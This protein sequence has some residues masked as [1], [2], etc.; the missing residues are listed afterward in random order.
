M[1]RYIRILRLPFI[2]SKGVGSTRHVK[3]NNRENLSYTLSKRSATYMLPTLV[4]V[5]WRC[6]SFSVRCSHYLLPL[7][8]T[9]MRTGAKLASLEDQD[10]F[11]L[12]IIMTIGGQRYTYIKREL[13]SQVI[14]QKASAATVTSYC[15]KIFDR[16]SYKLLCFLLK[17]IF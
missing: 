12:F 16:Y 15:F 17:S 5:E 11:P 2:A 10:M 3:K 6:N 8:N 14:C 1:E 4:E 13:Q 9:S 7:I